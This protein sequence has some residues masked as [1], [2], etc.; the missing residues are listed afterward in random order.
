MFKFFKSSFNQLKNSLA[1]TKNALGDKLASLFRKPWSAETLEELEQIL[2]EA[3]IGTV[4][5]QEALAYVQK[6]LKEKDPSLLLIQK[7][8]KEFFL[9]LFTKLPAPPETLPQKPLVILIVGVNGSGKTTTCAKLAK[10]YQDA[11][12]KVLFGAA[13]TFRAAA[14]EQ[15]G[16][17]AERLGIDI[18]R[19]QIGSDPSAVVFDTLEA[20][21]ARAM[22][23]VIIDTAGRLQTKTHLMQ[24]LEKIKRVM[25][26]IIPEAPHET[27]LV[28][29]ATCG[30]NAI[31]Q[32]KIFHESTPL[33]GFI[34]TKID[35]S[36]KGGILLPLTQELKIPTKYLGI[37]E[38]FEDFIEFSP[39]EYVDALF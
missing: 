23:V 35:G 22:D 7:A 28:L 25:K 27:F 3:D 31:D 2:Y 5:T 38:Q 1:K 15:L 18:I 19:S 21:K 14:S 4:C 37:G 24:E 29:D 11:G 20:A 8:L 12:K 32:A 26:K 33:T 34:L 39:E 6:H 36:A 9:S 10:K 13:D 17:W 30:Q 16:L